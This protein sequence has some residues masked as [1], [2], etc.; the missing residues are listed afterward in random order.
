MRFVEVGG[1]RI[2]YQRVGNGPPVVFVHGA[3]VDSRS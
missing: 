1:L 2:A 3:A